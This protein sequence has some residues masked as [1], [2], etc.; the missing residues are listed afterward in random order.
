MFLGLILGLLIHFFD[1]QANTLSHYAL[2]VKPLGV[3]FLNL[4]KML[5]VPLVF[6][7]I[8]MSVANIGNILSLGRLAKKTVLY[9]FVTTAMASI[10]G[11]ILVNIMQPGLHAPQLKAMLTQSMPPTL[12][13][14]QE[15]KTLFDILIYDTFL[16]VIPTNIFTSLTEGS[17]LQI[18]FFTLVFAIFVT[19]LGSKGKPIIDFMKAVEQAVMTMILWVMKFAPYGIFALILVMVTQTGTEAIS[20]MLRYMLTVTIGLFIHGFIVLPLILWFFGKYNPFIFSK[21]MLSALTTAF[22]TS[23]SAAALPVTLECVKDNAGVPEHIADFVV[24]LGATVNMDGTALYESVAAIFIAQIVGYQL[25]LTDQVII[26]ILATLAAVGAAAIPSAGLVTMGIVFKAVKLPLEGIGLIAGVDRPLD[27]M[28]TT[29]N[30]WG[31]AVGAIVVSRFEGEKLK[32][33]L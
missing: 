11:L 19:S 5:I 26:F 9:Y 27:M 30:V 3:I 23:S 15:G 13:S 21:H 16:Q 28:R 17:V 10:L 1:D 33:K 6:S 24:P 2:Y 14:A 25:G 29:V 22:S 7:T 4:L 20:V 31:D 12:V 32:P 18:I 8:F